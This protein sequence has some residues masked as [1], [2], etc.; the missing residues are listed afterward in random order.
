MPKHTR[1]ISQRIARGPPHVRACGQI[2]SYPD[3]VSASQLRSGRFGVDR[4]R[5]EAVGF[6]ALTRRLP[7]ELVRRIMEF[8]KSFAGVIVNHF[9]AHNS[10]IMAL[11]VWP[12]AAGSAGSSGLLASGDDFGI[13]HMRD[14]QYNLVSTIEGPASSVMALEFLS[15][16]SLAA[17]YF[18]GITKVWRTSDGTCLYTITRDESAYC[19][20]K[21][22]DGT[23][24]V[25]YDDGLIVFYRNGTI[26]TN[27]HTHTAPVVG[28]A[29]MA[30]GRMASCSRTGRVCI[31]ASNVYTVLEMADSAWSVCRLGSDLAVGCY[32]GT[33]AHIWND[34]RM[35]GLKTPHHFK[36]TALCE[37]PDGSLASGSADGQL[38]MSGAGGPLGRKL[39]GDI[40]AIATIPSAERLLPNGQIE[41]TSERVCVAAGF[42]L[43]TMV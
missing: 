27:I 40:N 10:T 25:G 22:P 17:V 30:D 15:D 13:I 20:L 19:L 41:R 39:R 16:G 33:I 23:L 43:Y 5:S 29:I 8:A 12:G 32:A 9:S 42:D 1:T 35:H 36:V 38:H 24:A 37:L 7:L 3:V 26:L 14:T 28:L 6:M 4:R 18:D 21:F 11:A 2:A 34:G 31:H